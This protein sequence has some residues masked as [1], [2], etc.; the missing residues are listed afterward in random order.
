MS[1]VLGR[2]K[3]LGLS[4]R[5]FIKER[6]HR[7]ISTTRLGNLD[8]DKFPY[9]IKAI[10][11]DYKKLREKG[12]KLK[13]LFNNGEEIR[14]ITDSG[15]DLTIG[16][17]KDKAIANIGNYQKPG[18]GGNMPAG[19]IYMPPKWRKVEGQVIIDCSGSYRWGTQLIKKQIKLVIE[20]GEIVDLTGGKE[21]EKLKETLDWAF[22][23]AK[24]P[25]G[26]RRIGELGIGINP[27]AEVIGATIVDEK[28][29]GT[30]HVAMG[31]NYWFV[32][33][34]DA[35][36]HLDQIFRNPKI[37]LDNEEIDVSK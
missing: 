25:W 15:T 14:V 8:T 5:S 2:L 9:L 30:A 33:T 29:L 20:K 28:S 31:S 37:Y 10:D 1:G 7:F 19:E 35:I 11:I 4:F 24:Y 32:G 17:D 16:L 12:E 26:I 36:I 13:E 27:N 21:A 23:K 22:K 18:K 6:R 3:E 34:I